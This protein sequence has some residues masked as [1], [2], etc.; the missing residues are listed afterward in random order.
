MGHL[1]ARLGK[2]GFFGASTLLV[3]NTSIRLKIK[4]A[5]LSKARELP[6]ACC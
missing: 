4:A 5:S 6:A 3:S 1:S 2:T